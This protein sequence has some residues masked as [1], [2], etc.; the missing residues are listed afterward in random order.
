M[1]LSLSLTVFSGWTPFLM[2]LP[3]QRDTPG[4]CVCRTHTHAQTASRCPTATCCC[5]WVTSPSWACP[6]RLRS[7][8]TGSVLSCLRT[9]STARHQ[10]L[11]LFS[12]SYEANMHRL[13]WAGARAEARDVL[14]AKPETGSHKD[15]HVCTHTHTHTPS[16]SAI[17]LTTNT[18][19]QHDGCVD[20]GLW[21]IDDPLRHITDTWPY[22][23]RD[24][25]LSS[26]SVARRHLLPDRWRTRLYGE[27]SFVTV[28]QQL[29]ETFSL[30]SVSHF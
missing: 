26:P 28:R 18:N 8:T 24:P 21:L 29:S 9:Y 14:H 19:R 3:S 11:A 25:S 16:S 13:S 30:V 15:T 22:K 6:P 4:L 27:I 5:T 20:G 1:T 17:L 2:T 10:T 7:S 23:E 12:H